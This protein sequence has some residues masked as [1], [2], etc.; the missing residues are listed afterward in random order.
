MGCWSASLH[1]S[2][3][4]GGSSQAVARSQ[5]SEFDF[6]RQ[7]IQKTSQ[8]PSVLCRKSALEVTICCLL[9]TMVF[10]VL[11]LHGEILLQGCVL[12]TTGR[13]GDIRSASDNL[14]ADCVAS[15]A[16]CGMDFERASQHHGGLSDLGLAVRFSDLRNLLSGRSQLCWSQERLESR[17]RKAVCLG[18]GEMQEASRATHPQLQCRAAVGIRLAREGAPSHGSSSRCSVIVR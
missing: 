8:I 10:C 9:A 4:D 17:R 11:S 6:D 14:W 18:L 1:L 16:I 12:F 2:V 15:F 5:T 7:K 13:G 3:W